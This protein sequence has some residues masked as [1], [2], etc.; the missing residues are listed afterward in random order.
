MTAIDAVQ[1][2]IASCP[3]GGFAIPEAPADSPVG[4]RPADVQQSRDGTL[5]WRVQHMGEDAKYI[6][7]EYFFEGQ[8]VT[9][10]EETF[11]AAP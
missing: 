1:G 2:L 3:R 4:S 8:W 9:A 10:V 5:R 6:A 7:A 11:P